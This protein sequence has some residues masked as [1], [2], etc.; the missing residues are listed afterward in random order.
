MMYNYMDSNDSFISVI[1]F[2]LLIIFGAFFTMNLVLAQIM[3]SF[4]QQQ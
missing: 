4:Y 3:D 1:F 2:C